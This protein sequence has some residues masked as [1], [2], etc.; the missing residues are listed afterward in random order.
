[1]TARS[2]KTAEWELGLSSPC[3]EPEESESKMMDGGALRV[4]PEE[5]EPEQGAQVVI[6]TG[7]IPPLFYA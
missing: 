2:K 4:E 3:V 1:M 5:E 7:P 6:P